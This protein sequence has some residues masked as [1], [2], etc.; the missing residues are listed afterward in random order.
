MRKSATSDTRL[1]FDRFERL[2]T[3]LLGKVKE[4]QLLRDRAR[5]RWFVEMEIIADCAHGTVQAARQRQF[6]PQLFKELTSLLEEVYFLFRESHSDLKKLLEFREEMISDCTVEMEK[7]AL[8]LKDIVE[9]TLDSERSKCHAIADQA[10]VIGNLEDKVAGLEATMRSLEMRVSQLSAE[11]DS[12][13][14]ENLR[15]RKTVDQQDYE[16]DKLQEELSV[17][18]KLQCKLAA[19]QESLLCCEDQNSRLCALKRE[20]EEKNCRLVT[21]NHDLA[22][23]ADIEHA[24]VRRLRQREE[25]FRTKI[26]AVNVS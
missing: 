14:K 19:A 2:N 11:K 1:L 20:L 22:K 17:I 3:K 13:E 5:E 9:S 10:E 12:L 8:D 24:E 4:D 25:E 15:M 26:D 7:C 18:P 21:Q 16:L 6:C 23:E